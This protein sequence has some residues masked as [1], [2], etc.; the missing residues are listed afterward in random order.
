MQDILPFIRN[1]LG[2]HIHPGGSVLDGTAG[3]GLDTLFLAQQVGRQGRVYAF[4]IQAEAIAATAALLNEHGLSERVQ[5]IH[6][7]HAKLADYIAPESLDAAVFNFGYLPKGDKSI[8]TLA[9]SSIPAINA[10]LHC[11]RPQ[12]L[13]AA[14]LYPGHAAGREETTALFAHAATL[15]P[16][17][18]DIIRY[19]WVNRPNHPPTALLIRKR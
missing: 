18:F 14:A 8:T 10:A 2:L 12:G 17:Q 13:L 4:D 5:L 11:L 7:S 6:D 9:E 1:H 16:Q 15:P 3:R 19:G